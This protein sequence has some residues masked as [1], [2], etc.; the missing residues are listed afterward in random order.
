[1]TEPGTQAPPAAGTFCW[2]E[3]MTRDLGAAK[4]F[5]ASLFG[6]TSEEVDMGPVGTYTICK[7]GEQHAGGMMELKAPG[8]EDVTPHWVAYVAVDNVDESTAKAEGLGARICV[9]PTDIPN[10]GRFSIITDPTGASLGL[11]TSSR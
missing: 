3:L 11:Y 9:P 7:S 10:V 6:W 4:K 2:N 1:M 8:T 5:Y